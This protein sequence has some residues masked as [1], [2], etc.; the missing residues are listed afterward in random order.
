MIKLVTIVTL[1]AATLGT[2]CKKKES[3]EA[4]R[5]G[6]APKTTEQVAP[7]TTEQVRP[8]E[9]AQ[10]GQMGQPGEQTQ[11]NQMAPGEKSPEATALPPECVEYKAT[12]EK[13]RTCDQL[14]QS[15]RDALVQAYNQASSGW[16]KATPETRASLASSCK[17]ANQAIQQ[18][19][20]Q[21]P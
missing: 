1:V 16:E 12:I 5:S 11:P 9:Q 4:D 3:P 15:T 21:C 8:S 2:G 6:M 10:P 14:P 13:I 19:A 17:S 20:A 18:S 7:G